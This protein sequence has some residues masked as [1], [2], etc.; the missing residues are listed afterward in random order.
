MAN[1]AEIQQDP[2]GDAFLVLNALRAFQARAE[3]FLC[4]R[5]DSVL[6]RCGCVQ[7]C[8]STVALL[9]FH[10]DYF[11]RTVV[12][13][14]V[15]D[16]DFVN[17]KDSE[18]WTLIAYD[19]GVWARDW[20]EIIQPTKYSHFETRFPD[21]RRVRFEGT[22]WTDERLKP[23]CYSRLRPRT[24]VWR[25]DG[26]SGVAGATSYRDPF[27]FLIISLPRCGREDCLPHEGGGP[28]SQRGK[29][30]EDVG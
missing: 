2:S 9:S 15:Y 13:G 4:G 23:V 3:L 1:L 17:P 24:V 25:Q 30:S 14:W 18:S 28:D 5:Q 7:L 22:L 8:A 10:I 11:L 21:G 6:Y 19:V 20:T 12:E 29:D 16:K 26:V 27:I